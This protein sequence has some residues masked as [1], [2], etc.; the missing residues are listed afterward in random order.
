M[1]SRIPDE[2]IVL[3][4]LLVVFL[5]RAAIAHAIVPPW[6]GPD[7]PGHFSRAYQ[8]GLP[9][10]LQSVADAEI[11]QSMVRHGWW[12][13]YEDPPP[14]QLKAI[15]DVYGLGIGTLA[16]PLYYSIAGVVLR[17]SRP[18]DVDTAYTHLR[19]LSVVLAAVTLML[20]WAGSRVLLGP[21]VALGSTAIGMLHPQFL[22]SA[23]SVNADALLFTCG[24]FVWWQA[25]RAIT[26]HR[27]DLSVA[28]MLVGSV[29]A[30]FAKR[31]GL[32][33]IGT[34]AAVAVA[35]FYVNRTH[36]FGRRDVL[37]MSGVGIAGA[38]VVAAAWLLFQEQVVYWK[39]MLID[40][41][42]I[43]RPLDQA[44]ASEAL[45]FLRMAVDYFWLIGGWLQ[46]QPPKSWLWVARV[47]VVGGLVGAA[48]VFLESRGDRTRQAVAWFFMMVQ[49]IAMLVVV[50]WI[51]TPSAP[52]ARYLFPAFVPIT[53]VLYIGLRR[54]VPSAIHRYWP[55]V[56]V[57]LLALMDFTGFTTVHIPTYV[58]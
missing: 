22:L 7:E 25:A 16:Y 56:L 24:A 26:G 51:T 8:V 27:R 32:V 9:M 52:Q 54:L 36:R 41:F 29:A 3:A 46:F 12:A 19:F 23:I 39:Y 48:V 31:W 35:A 18:A 15:Q 1:T 50:F 30:M 53:V 13:L 45:R 17:V 20:G 6:Q 42:T 21:E 43:R 49:V 38:A 33:L 34:A 40:V 2:R 58:R 55:A 57:V 5:C 47:L 4:G 28:L 44:T 14:Q 10:K 11:L 37:L